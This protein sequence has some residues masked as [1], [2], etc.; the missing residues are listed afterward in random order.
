LPP[1]SFP[2][3]GPPWSN[4][5]GKIAMPHRMRPSGGGVPPPDQRPKA[6][7]NVGVAPERPR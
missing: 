7:T 2:K 4:R 5:I 3:D 6:A 1:L